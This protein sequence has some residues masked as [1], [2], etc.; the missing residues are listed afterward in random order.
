MKA[1]HTCPRIVLE[2]ELVNLPRISLPFEKA[3]STLTLMCM[4]GGGIST[5]VE[6]HHELTWIHF[7]LTQ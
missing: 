2:S 7:R 1:D 6:V 5:T 3:P 4:A